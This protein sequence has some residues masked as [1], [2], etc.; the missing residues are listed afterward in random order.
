MPEA[1][2]SVLAVSDGSTPVY[3][4]R[5]CRV[6]IDRDVATAFGTETKR[7]NEAKRRNPEKFSIT[8]AFQLS[9]EE[10]SKLK[11][12]RATSTKGRGGWTRPPWAYTVKGV[13]RLAMILDTPEALDASDKILDTFLLV[14]E[15]IAQGKTE[16][17][18]SRPTDVLPEDAD[19]EAALKI[20]KRLL[21]TVSALADSVF[22]L[23]EQRQAR[24]NATKVRGKIWNDAMERLRTKGLENEKL[25]ADTELVLAEARKLNAE[26]D[27]LDLDNL[28]KRIKV[29]ERAYQL[30]RNMEP[31]MVISLMGETVA[32][33]PK[34]LRGR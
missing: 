15:Q 11:S 29:A 18:I 31:N 16:I 24:E 23:E 20:R 5:G 8:H 28:E 6:V 34:A 3:L 4:I 27:G 30:Y 2:S 13:G 22:T 7:I 17:T 26:A 14:Q 9:K 32:S 21:K 19:R 25:I 1:P 12:Q 33:S 10:F